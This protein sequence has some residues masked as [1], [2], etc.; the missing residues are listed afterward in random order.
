ME[1]LDARTALEDEAELQSAGDLQRATHEFWRFTMTSVLQLWLTAQG[2][3]PQPTLLALSDFA[4][5]SG[6]RA[7]EGRAARNDEGLETLESAAGEPAAEGRTA[8]HDDSSVDGNKERRPP[9]C[10]QRD[11]VQRY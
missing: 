3:E 6:E 10:S 7:A 1:W 9:P 8:R 5:T 11:F 2:Q 4:N